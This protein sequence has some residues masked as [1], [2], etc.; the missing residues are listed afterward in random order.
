M[1]SYELLKALKKLSYIKDERDPYWWPNSGSFEVVIGAI[2][3]QQTK[4][5]KVEKSLQ[6][7][8]DKNILDLNSISEMQTKE[9][10]ELIK[11]SGFY[12][13]KAKRVITLC[14]NIKEEFDNFET[15]KDNVQRQWLLEQKG[16]GFE[17]ADS[18]LCYGCYKEVMVGDSYT[19]RLLSAFGFEFE[20][21]DEMTEWLK[22]G[23]Y[24]NLEKIY[25]LYEKEISTTQIF[26]RFHGKI[27]EYCKDFM[28]GKKVNTER[29]KN[30][31]IYSP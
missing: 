26:A 25:P 22:E 21:Y 2:L 24:E 14:K 18:I 13:T 19:H 1:N 16:I 15:F 11:P 9:L 28:K 8:R 30:M 17:S 23:I 31:D 12:N 27:V 6:N 4:W 29:I 7:L 5:E 3:T 10:G 20:T